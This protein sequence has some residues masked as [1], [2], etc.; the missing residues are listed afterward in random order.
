M[1]Y[2]PS[3]NDDKR[4]TKIIEPW[5]LNALNKMS[6]GETWLRIRK[7]DVFDK[8]SLGGFKEKEQYEKYVEKKG[9][10]VYWR[11]VENVVNSLVS[12]NFIKRA[13]NKAEVMIRQEGIDMCNKEDGWH[14][15]RYPIS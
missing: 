7:I 6:R 5:F 12:Q 14:S 2:T 3:V 10:D 15:S 9:S 1:E 8:A 13:Q 4:Y 11:L